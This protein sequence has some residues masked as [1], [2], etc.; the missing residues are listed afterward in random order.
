M[1]D[2]ITELV[3]HGQ[4]YTLS[5]PCIINGNGTEY[6][7][8]YYN[9]LRKSAASF[10]E[11]NNSRIRHYKSRYRTFTDGDSVI[12]EVT[13]NARIKERGKHVENRSKLIRDVWNNG[14][15]ISRFISE[16]DI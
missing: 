2:K 4:N 7:S 11:E 14:K 16:S 8:T 9:R 3:T 13:L 1:T 15:L 10:A 5:L 12:I 6:F